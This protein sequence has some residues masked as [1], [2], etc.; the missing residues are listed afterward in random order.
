MKDLKDM[1]ITWGNPIA[2]FMTFKTFMV[3]SSP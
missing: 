3:H 2:F 1:K